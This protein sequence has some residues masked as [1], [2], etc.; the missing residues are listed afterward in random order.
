MKNNK[1]RVILF[2]LLIVIAVGSIGIGVTNAQFTTANLWKREGTSLLPSKTSNTIGSA[3]SRVSAIYTS[4]LD[5]TSVSIA[6]A[7]S[8]PLTVSGLTTSYGGFTGP[9]FTATSTSVTSTFA[10]PLSSSRILVDNGTGSAPGFTFADAPNTGIYRLGNSV[11]IAANSVRTASFYATLL[12]IAV[13]IGPTTDNALDV[14]SDTFRFNDGFFGGTV[15]AETVSTTNMTLTT[16]AGTAAYSV[17]ANADRSL[18]LKLGA[19][20]F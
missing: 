16:D 1:I 6:G 2:S 8:G 12:N 19:N 18:F 13:P 17:C 7:V 3:I 9:F 15:F 4:L 10:G 5:A 20:C 14:G 11:S